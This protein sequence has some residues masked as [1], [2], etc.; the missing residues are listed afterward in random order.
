MKTLK[1]GKQ[2]LKKAN[3]SDTDMAQICSSTPLLK[4]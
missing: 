1:N 4:P 3:Q 2:M